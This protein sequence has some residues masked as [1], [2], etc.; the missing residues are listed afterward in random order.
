MRRRERGGLFMSRPVIVVGV[1]NLYRRDDSV[2]LVALEKLQ[3]NNLSSVMFVANTGDGAALLETWT[4]DSSVILIDAAVSDAPAGT[5]LRFDTLTQLLP[6]DFFFAST[7]T[8]GIAEA[9]RLA[10]T[11]QRLP[12][13]LVIYA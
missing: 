7:H 11:L 9:I 13:R 8:F 3:A 6:T 2:G 5:I 10:Y 4:Q 1:G 12:K